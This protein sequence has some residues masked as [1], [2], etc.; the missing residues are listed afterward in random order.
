VSFI[1]RIRPGPRLCVAFRNEFV[2]YGEGLLA[3]R[4]TPKLEDHPLSFVRP[5]LFSIF[6]SLPPTGG[7]P[8]YPQPEDTPC[9]GDKGTHLNMAYMST[10][11][12]KSEWILIYLKIV[13]LYEMAE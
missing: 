11:L 2:L 10:S 12:P 9:C 3:P 1:Q 4:P 8:F 5:C 7:R 6:R 13:V